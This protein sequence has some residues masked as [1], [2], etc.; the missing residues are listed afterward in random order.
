MALRDDLDAAL[1]DFRSFLAHRYPDVRVS[2]WNTVKPRHFRT[3]LLR[4]QED[5]ELVAESLRVGKAPY[6]FH[7]DYDEAHQPVWVSEGWIKP[8]FGSPGSTWALMLWW[9]E[10]NMRN[11]E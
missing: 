3:S 1:A 11:R 10:N 6:K 8:T 5:P 2:S 4:I 9:A 7:P